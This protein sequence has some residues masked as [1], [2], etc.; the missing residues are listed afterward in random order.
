M[1]AVPGSRSLTLKSRLPATLQRAYGTGAGAGPGASAASGSGSGGGACDGGAA[2]ITPLTFQLPSQLAEWRQWMEQHPDEEEGAEEGAE[3]TQ[4]RRRRQRLW[5]LKTAQHLG[6]SEGWGA[7][8][9]VGRGCGAVGLWGVRCVCAARLPLSPDM[10][11]STSSPLRPA[12]PC[13]SGRGLQLVPQREAYLA[14]LRRQAAVL[15]FRAA[16]AKQPGGGGGAGKAAAAA[17][18]RRPGPHEP[19]PFTVR[20]E[21]AG[22]L[23]RCMEGGA[24][25]RRDTLLCAPRCQQVMTP[26]VRTC[27]AA[28]AS[29]CASLCASPSTP[30]HLH[31]ST[32]PPRQVA[33]QYVSD[34]L[35]LTPRAAAGDGTTAA[36]TAA[37]AATAAAAAAS[38]AAGGRKFGVRLWL[39]LVGG[40]GAASD[41]L[42]AYLHKNGA[43][44]V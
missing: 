14:V 11:S 41:P 5:M 17:R 15:A 22:V 12:P 36:A 28:S 35:L 7:T 19:R 18:R 13:S 43:R 3:R 23:Q 37:S 26:A 34:P 42:R 30:P 8:A 21:G 39:V 10:L 1:C 6:G 2:D 38:A 44:R 4:P 29:P 20:V 25:V 27:T 31:T 32:P 16:A 24:A 9:A 33:Q 40:S